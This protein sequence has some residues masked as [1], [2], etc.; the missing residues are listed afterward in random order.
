MQIST[1]TRYAVRALIELTYSYEKGPLQLREIAKR[2]NISEKYLEQIMH[3]LRTKGF[4]YSQK[5]SQGG[6]CLAKPP[7]S[8]TVYDLVDTMEGTT[9]PVACVDKPQVCDRI[10]VC[11]TREVWSRLKDCVAREL[12]SHTLEQLARKEAKMKS[13]QAESLNYQI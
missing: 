8:I 10:D 11:S 1:K 6:Y 5:G 9:S 2:Q 13:S 4:V 12:K 7:D 3:P